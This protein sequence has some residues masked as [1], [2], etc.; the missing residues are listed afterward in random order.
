MTFTTTEYPPRP[1]Y[2]VPE[3]IQ[4]DTLL[5]L[6]SD[7]HSG[8]STALFPHYRDL[9]DGFWQFKHTRYVP[10]GKQC[11]LADHWDYCA[12][13]LAIARVGKRL[14]IVG[15]GD[16]TDGKHHDTLQLATHNPDEQ[17]EVNI[18]LMQRFMKRVGFDHS[19]GDKFYVLSGTE[20]HTKDKEDLI[21]KEL[22]AENN[23]EGTEI[24]D[25]L[26][27]DINGKLFWFLHQGAGP[28]KG[29][30]IGNALVG[31]MRNKYFELLEAGE[32][33]P[34]AVV[35]GHYHVPVYTT[36]TRNYRTMHGVILPSWQFK[37][38][39]GYKVAAAER[40]NIGLTTIDVSSA[41]NILVNKPYLLAKRDEVI[42]A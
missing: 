40:E 10:S 1:F 30:N 6:P 24:F 3:K 14:I 2:V 9:Q 8:G 37:T 20:T 5:A 4:K 33:I 29:A 38:R 26:P 25:F 28:G 12:D 39:F 22:Q 17:M 31:W 16:M 32:R 15:M 13:Q 21:A 23:P 19:R 35:S 41:G 11:D 7:M 27:L 36:F 34:D 18:W 42:Y